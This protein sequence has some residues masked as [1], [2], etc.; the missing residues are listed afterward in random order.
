MDFRYAFLSL[1]LLLSFPRLALSQQTSNEINELLSKSDELRYSNTDSSQFYANK[2]LI[3]SKGSESDFGIASAH[4]RLGAVYQIKGD[5]DSSKMHSLRAL[6]IFQNLQ[7][8]LETAETLNNLGIVYDEQGR[9]DEAVDYYI[10]ALD[11]YESLSDQKGMAKV[12]NNLGII[13]KK[14][15][16]YERVVF[17]Y[18]KS[19]KI[20]TALD[21]KIGI[22]ITKGNIGSALLETHQYDS[23]ILYSIESISRYKEAGLEQYVPYSLENIGLA[24]KEK[25]DLKSAEKYHNE[26][27]KLYENF[28]N[29]KESA[30]TLGS[31]AEINLVLGRY[32]SSRALASRALTIATEI[33]AL[34]ELQRA[35]LILVKSNLF[36]DKTQEAISSFDEFILY[37]DSL[38]SKKRNEAIEGVQTKYE[39]EKKEQAIKSL[40]A[41]AELMDLRNERNRYLIL[42]IIVAS[43]MMAGFL[44][45]NF[46]RKNYKLRAQMSEE[47][48]R[49][50]K[51]RFRAVVEAEEKERKRIAQELHDGLGQL[52]SAV[53]LNISSLDE[54]ETD[55]KIQNSVHLVDA[56]V[57]EVRTI[58][59]NMMPTALTKIGLSAALRDLIRSIQESGKVNAKFTESGKIALNESK[60]VAIFRI[61]QEV[62]NNTMKYA[63]ASKINLNLSS[64]KDHLLVEIVD[65]GVGFDTN[66][67][68]NSKGI[69]WKNI[70]SRVD[71]LG[72][73]IDIYSK[74][75][76]GTTVRIKLP[77]ERTHQTAT[78]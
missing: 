63:N 49:I 47:K 52:L 69:G 17:Y 60:S 45:L 25:N 42:A 35:N 50:Q 6:G 9:D 24:Y 5:Y 4:Q 18:K 11:I 43:F 62:I 59:H 7:D 58:S 46:K 40:E 1:F 55:K 3:L 39:T 32:A 14:N 44:F 33:G 19:L 12:Y 75:G 15:K 29:K 41:E 77:D 61:A 53:R 26:A 22:A 66:Q 70:H 64:G 37:S 23:S 30:F 34:E 2:A 72:G 71:L 38:N 67:I 28:G 51:N 8:E 73:E 54:D 27:L 56:A 20:Y 57:G 68:K 65:D 31:L 13:N 48:E 16:H 78:G 21:H 36:L 74:L 76:S 10:K